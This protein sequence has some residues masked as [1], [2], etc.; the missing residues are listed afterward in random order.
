MSKQGS[1]PGDFWAESVKILSLSSPIGPMLRSLLIRGTFYRFL[2]NNGKSSWSLDLQLVLSQTQLVGSPP[3][4][5]GR[6]GK[7]RWGKASTI[8]QISKTGKVPSRATWQTDVPHLILNAGS[9]LTCAGSRNCGI[10][11]ESVRD[12]HHQNPWDSFRNAIVWYTWFPVYPAARPVHVLKT[13]R[14]V[15]QGLPRATYITKASAC[16]T[17]YKIHWRIYIPGRNRGAPWE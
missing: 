8:V 1:G 11:S 4:I 10:R 13:N 3:S 5:E 9:W 6:Q 15:Y 14:S 16:D 17:L 2:G 12:M 7:A